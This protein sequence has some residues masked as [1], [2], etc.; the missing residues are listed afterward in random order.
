MNSQ[1]LNS[2]TYKILNKSSELVT[3]L[4]GSIY[5][6][7]FRPTDSL[8]DDICVNVLA[9]TD[10]SPQI[11]IANINIYVADQKQ[12]IYGKENNVPNYSRLSQLSDLV[13]KALNDGL[14]DPEFENIGF[15][16]LENRDFQNEGN[17]RPEHY[18]NIRVQYI[19][20]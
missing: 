7:N 14:T 9:L 8:K 11:G 6:G 16:I 12:T 15:S 10:R 18:Q 4:G 20:T 2:V 17:T 3:T 19:I 1:Q 13:E 5:K